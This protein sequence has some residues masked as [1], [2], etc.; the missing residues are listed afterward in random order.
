MNP[1]VLNFPVVI[2]A[3]ISPT[4][5]FNPGPANNFPAPHHLTPSSNFRAC[6]VYTLPTNFNIFFNQM[7]L[8]NPNVQPSGMG[9]PSITQ[10]LLVNGS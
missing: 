5:L 4:A 3:G 7:F 1:Q 10:L 9:N 2:Q 8:A 6:G